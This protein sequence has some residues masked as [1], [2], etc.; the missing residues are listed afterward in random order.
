M[1][2][3]RPN[4][5]LG[6]VHA[7]GVIGC[8]FGL[9]HPLCDKRATWHLMAAS[10]EYCLLACEEHLAYIDSLDNDVVDRHPV[11][12]ICNIP[13]ALWRFSGTEAEGFCAF[14]LPDTADALT[15]QHE[16][17]RA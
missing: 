8:G 16:E 17:S 3:G 13:G 1:S 14:P 5:N 12:G 6:E 11:G 2:N 4:L 7:E 15:S 10:N 9:T